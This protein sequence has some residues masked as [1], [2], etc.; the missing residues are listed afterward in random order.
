[1]SRKLY[2]LRG[3]GGQK[4][5]SGKTESVDWADRWLADGLEVCETP[6]GAGF[7]QIDVSSL[8]V[9]MEL[10][11]QQGR[12]VSFIGVLTRAAGLAIQRHPYLH[13]IA[14]GRNRRHY[15]THIDIG[16]SQ[17]GETFVSPVLL[18][19]KAENKRAADISMEITARLPEISR[20]EQKLLGFFR[21]WGWLVPV[22]MFRRMI[23]RWL[24]GQVWFRKGAGVMQL[25]YIPHLSK[26]VAMQFSATAILGIGGIHP[27]VIAVDGQATVRPIIWASCAMNHRVWDGLSGARFFNEFTKILESV[28][29]EL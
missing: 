14:V 11:R 13:K 27:E 7:V 3:R 8:Q 28:D 21:K 1:V 26:F 25:S 4:P 6:G 29:P 16:V 24:L 23:I 17:A 5:F 15:P 2:Y 22:P 10:Q 20:Q 9:W 18:I 12:P 19:E